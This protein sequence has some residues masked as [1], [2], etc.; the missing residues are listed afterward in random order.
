[1]PAILAVPVN[2]FF[3]L[4]APPGIAAA[5][6]QNANNVLVS[7][8]ASAPFGAVS[9]VSDLGLARVIESNSTH[10]TSAARGTM[11]HMPPEQLRSGQ[12]SA[13]G[14]I[15][16]F[17]V[18]MSRA[19][20]RRGCLQEAAQHVGQ[21]SRPLCCTTCQPAGPPATCLRT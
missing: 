12:L 13:A 20:Q 17:G 15:Y 3:L 21:F 9:K 1:V 11:N 2:T 14:D 18:M 8:S 16:A 5:D 4:I 10:H 19:V 7:S 6:L